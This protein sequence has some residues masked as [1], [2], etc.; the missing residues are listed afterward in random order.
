MTLFAHRDQPSDKDL[1][2]AGIMCTYASIGDI[3]GLSKCKEKGISLDACDYDFRTP[4][5]LA[6]ALGR[7]DT[8]KWLIENGANLTSADRFGGMAIHDALRNHHSE[9]AEYLENLSYEADIKYENPL[10]E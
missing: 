8:V 9:I 10:D 4:L 5:H 7:F 6:A 3:A 1:E 2:D